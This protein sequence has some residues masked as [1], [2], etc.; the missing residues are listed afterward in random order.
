MQLR[1]K[2]SKSFKV[3]MLISPEREQSESRS[4]VH[5]VSLSRCVLNI[6]TRTTHRP[7]QAPS[8]LYAIP[9]QWLSL[10]K[11]DGA[12]WGPVSMS[13]LSHHFSGCLPPSSAFEWS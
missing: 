10:A 2:E 8:S 7:R 5:T 4:H 9:V 12:L 13:P 1:R 6:T 11:T 3:I